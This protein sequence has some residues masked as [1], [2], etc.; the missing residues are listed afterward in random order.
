MSREF[1]AGDEIRWASGAAVSTGAMSWAAVVRLTGTDASWQT[2]IHG[3]TSGNAFTAGIGRSSNNRVTYTSVTGSPDDGG[4]S[5]AHLVADNWLIVVVTKA[6]GTS[7]AQYYVYKFDTS[8]WTNG[9]APLAGGI[10]NGQPVGT[11][12]QIRTGLFNGTDDQLVG[13]LAALAWWNTALSQSDVNSLA[14]TFTRANWLSKSP[15]WM[16]DT[17][18]GMV[19]DLS[20]G[21]TGDQT[22]DTGTADSA[23]NPAGW[24]S[25]AGTI[26]GYVAAGTVATATSGNVTA[27]NPSGAQTNDIHILDITALDNVDCSVANSGGSGASWTR[28]VA[29][30]NGTGLRKEIWWKR[31]AGG[32]TDTGATVTH[33]S[34]GKIIAR[35]HL[36]RFANGPT[37]GDPFEAVGGP[38]S[39][40]AAASG[41]FPSVTTV[42]ANAELFY[43]LG[44]AEDFTTGPSI[45]N[46]QGLTLTER[47]E[48]EVT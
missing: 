28:K 48:T 42:G 3:Y 29:H 16:V 21:G 1:G 5:T 38:T 31:R 43:S 33:A 8:S 36:Y 23:D 44:Y 19:N 2:Y 18:D 27:A 39:V 40:S 37:S 41:T 26:E 47:D 14:T 9:G 32:D 12:A 34:G 45:S 30:N 17:A 7:T 11:M 35:Q 10:S 25:W 24:A 13:R 15:A 20:S 6:T 4:A 46:A 22:L